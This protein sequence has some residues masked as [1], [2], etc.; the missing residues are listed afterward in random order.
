VSRTDPP[1]LRS[2]RSLRPVASGAG[3]K[4]IATVP[5]P[6]ATTPAGRGKGRPPSAGACCPPGRT[7]NGVRA[8][9]PPGEPIRFPHARKRARLPL[10]LTPSSSQNHRLPTHAHSERNTMTDPPVN[11]G[12]QQLDTLTSHPRAQ[13]YALL[14]SIN[15][16]VRQGVPQ[17][18]IA[19][20]LCAAGIPMTYPALRST[21]S[22]WRRSRG[23]SNGAPPSIA[24]SA[25]RHANKADSA[26]P[27][28]AP[29]ARLRDKG[30]ITPTDLKRLRENTRIDLNELAELGRRK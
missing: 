26:E 8:S 27:V 16:L 9:D 24:S 13:L 28:D 10:P 14:P 12:V 30:Y 21:L 1:A 3:L 6:A 17:Q 19:D 22:R 29:P 2:L 18:A 5:H 7:P 11:T 15:A 20:A 23:G 25:P 4:L